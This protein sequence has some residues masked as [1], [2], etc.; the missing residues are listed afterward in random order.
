M[1]VQYVL[2]PRRKWSIYERQH[3]AFTDRRSEMCKKKR[4][5]RQGSIRSKDNER[6]K[7][8]RRRDTKPMRKREGKGKKG[9]V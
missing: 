3:K 2:E 9:L 1:F 7:V 4:L 8:T 6:K 5:R